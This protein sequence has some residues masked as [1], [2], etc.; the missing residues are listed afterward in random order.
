[1]KYFLFFILV[2]YSIFAKSQDT[3]KFN[4]RIF[5]TIKGEFEIEMSKDTTFDNKELLNILIPFIEANIK[6]KETIN[7]RTIKII[8]T[9]K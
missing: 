4:L 2:F 1:M 3:L 7:R 5:K 9:T 8:K 6:I